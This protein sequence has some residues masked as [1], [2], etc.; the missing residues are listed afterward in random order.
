[1]NNRKEFIG[2]G[3]PSVDYDN[4]NCESDQKREATAEMPDPLIAVLFSSSTVV[5]QIRATWCSK[6]NYYFYLSLLKDVR[7]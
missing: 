2:G 3:P 7:Q 5:F 6:Y 1:M 4:F